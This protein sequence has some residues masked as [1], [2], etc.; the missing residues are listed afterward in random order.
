MGLPSETEDLSR[1]ADLAGIAM[2]GGV[3]GTGAGGMAVGSG[4][5]RAYHGSPHDFDRFD[6]SKIGT[7][8][9]AQARL[10]RYGHAPVGVPRHPRRSCCG[11]CRN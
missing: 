6:L 4:P 2:T 10:R 5:I 11:C 1:V 7:G 9:G 3:A 8:E